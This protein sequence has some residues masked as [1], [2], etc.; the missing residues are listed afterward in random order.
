MKIKTFKKQLSIKDI[1]LKSYKIMKKLNTIEDEEPINLENIDEMK[2]KSLLLKL[3]KS[4]KLSGNDFIEKDEDLLKAANLLYKIPSLQKFYKEYSIT[5][6]SLKEMLSFIEIKYLYKGNCLFNQDE[7]PNEMFVLLEGQLSLKYYNNIKQEST[8]EAYVINEFNLD[9]FHYR[10]FN[11]LCDNMDKI[12]KRKTFRKPISK[13]I[14]FNIE[15]DNFLND[16]NFQNEEEIEYLIINDERFISQNNLLTLSPHS[17]NCYVSSNECLVLVLDKKSFNISIQKNFMRYDLEYKKFIC[18]RMNVFEKFHNETLNIYFYSWIKI[19]P[20]TH[21]KIFS[22]NDEAKYFYLLYNGECINIISNRN[23]NIFS[24]G[25]FIGLDCL[26]NPNKKYTSTVICK[27]DNT[28]LF[29]FNPLSFNEK[30]LNELKTELNQ[31][32]EIKQQNSNDFILKKENMENKFKHNYFHLT[33]D[34]IQ[35]QLKQNEDRVDLLERNP[36]NMNILS[37][38]KERDKEKLS[39]NNKKHNKL[40]I[41]LNKIKNSIIIKKN[42]TQTNTEVNLIKYTNFSINKNIPKISLKKRDV[43]NL[44]SLNSS[45]SLIKN[46]TFSKRKYN[47]KKIIKKFPKTNYSRLFLGKQLIS[48][49]NINRKSSPLSI[50][51]LSEDLELTLYSSYADPI[52]KKSSFFE[53]QSICNDVDLLTLTDK[54]NHPNLFFNNNINRN[55]KTLI[56]KVELSCD[57]WKKTLNDSKRVFTTKHYKLP[58]IS[59]INE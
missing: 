24:K 22:F 40:F 50:L 29:K 15:N 43:L 21:E 35:D 4:I 12:I 57:K 49:R 9:Y 44:E 45:S 32:Y 8:L 56:Q 10:N 27:D 41:S 51:K 19:Y 20:K 5:V 37:E 13:N 3:L 14:N 7:I 38:E 36:F 30:I 48:S 54:G 6:K 28:I 53:N 17:I 46:R 42:K 55:K 34:Y 33:K 11:N 58:L 2:S 59:S 47:K 16:S 1:R 39:V 52:N 23:I 26:F 18:S 25:S 31:F